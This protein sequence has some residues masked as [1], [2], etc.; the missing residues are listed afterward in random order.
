[1]KGQCKSL[2]RI[3]L[4]STGLMLSGL[5]AAQADNQS[6]AKTIFYAQTLNH[7]KEVAICIDTPYVSY[8]FGKTGTAH[9][10]MDITVPA[11]NTTY[12][13]QSNELISIQEFT[14]RNGDTR[15]QVSAGT[16]DSGEPVASLYVFKG[17]PDTGKLLAEIK[18]DRD[19]VVNNISHSLAEDGVI[20]ADSL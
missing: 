17:A 15:Y 19:T 4:L 16:N 20:Q 1:M 8:S 2:T 11:A 6:C 7:N 13:Y 14:V 3:F 18:L 5:H 9:K 12:A 10:D